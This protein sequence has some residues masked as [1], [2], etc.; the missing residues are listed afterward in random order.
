M[1]KDKKRWTMTNW[2]KQEQTST[3]KDKQGWTRLNRDI[4]KEEQGQLRWTT[5]NK[6]KQWKTS[7]NKDK[8][9]Q[10]RINKDKQ[11]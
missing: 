2:V 4:N 3:T 7:I 9:G 11:G 5:M 10:T 8:Q 1:K 6:G